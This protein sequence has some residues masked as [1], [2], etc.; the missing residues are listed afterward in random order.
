MAK[1]VVGQYVRCPR[2]ATQEPYFPRENKSKQERRQIINTEMFQEIRVLGVRRRRR[3]RRNVQYSDECKESFLEKIYGPTS[4]TEVFFEI[5][6]FYMYIC[7][8]DDL[9]SQKRDV[10]SPGTRIINGYEP[11]C[12]FWE[13]NTGTLQ[14]QACLSLGVCM[15]MCECGICGCR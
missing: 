11:S 5:Y 8:P 15:Y 12:G 7:V 4:L 3:R 2:C 9:K 1:L 14:E 10:G 6:L 13:L